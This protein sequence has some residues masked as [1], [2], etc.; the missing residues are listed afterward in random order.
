MKKYNLLLICALIIMGGC[1]ENDI[2]YPRIAQNITALSAEGELKP[3]YIDS[4]A[5]EATVYLEETV[6]IQK[7]KFTEYKVSKDGVSDPDLLEGTY[8]MT[9]PLFV[10]ISRF[11]D[12][13]WE[14]KAVQDIERYFRVD[15]E[16]GASVVDAAAHRVV[17]SMPEGTNLAHLTLKDVKLGPAGITTITPELVPGPLDLSYP[18]RVEVECFGRA[19]IWTIYAQLTETVVSTTAADAWSRVVWVYGEGPSDVRNSIQYR[20]ADA[21][22]WITVPESEIV[23][24]QGDFYTA[25]PHLEPLTE[26]VVRTV[27]GEDIGNEIK[28]TT[29]PTADIPDGDFEN[30]SMSGKM[31]VPW[32][33]NG[34]K[35]WDTGNKGSITLGVNL[36]LP[37]DH[38][39]TGR[40]KAAECNTRFVGI[41]A[42]GKLGAGS[43]FTG[44]FSRL[45][46]TN[47]VLDFGR[48]FNLRPTK[49]KGYFQYK[50]APINY[51]SAEFQALKD[52][53]DTCHIY[54]A[55]TDWTAPFE[56]R[57]NPSNRQVLDKNASY[58]I[59]Y[60]ELSYSGTMDAYQP[61]EIKINY[62]STSRV[63]TYLQITAATSKYGD[64]F[65][66]GAGAVLYVDEFSF[67]YD[68]NNGEF[69]KI[70]R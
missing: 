19:E 39:V 70:K 14:I 38:T 49:L 23:Q 30:W 25:I 53:P 22:D 33:E 11:Q 61:F 45:D 64:Y 18:L 48:P 17:V 9:H 32:D 55:L 4:I 65:T 46:G 43:I 5:F 28:V 26:Y 6:D 29:Q 67:D 58:I 69:K 21:S 44:S 66:G 47:G 20:R 40:G 10:T 62:K 57:T 31:W 7:V 15:G 36:T 24:N 42:I 27:S 1:I 12:Y 35:Y 50:T 60:G 16:V 52:R 3:A 2:P 41:G 56:V 59:G 13:V 68:L 37:T 51:V 63:P 34:E 8:D 54:V